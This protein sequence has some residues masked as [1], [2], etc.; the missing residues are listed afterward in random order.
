VQAA[1][2]KIVAEVSAVSKPAWVLVSQLHPLNFEADVLTLEFESQAEVDAFK[3]SRG[4]P[5]TLRSAIKT[6]LGITVKFKPAIGA[7]K[8]VAAAAT[9]VAEP[10]A[11]EEVE[12][13]AVVEVEP[14]EQPSEPEAVTAKQNLVHEGATFGEAVLRDVLGATPIE[15]KK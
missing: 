1:W 8:P 11:Q 10:E 13:E 9:K 12:P 15:K 3:N 2:P 4:A 5:D 14:E 6:V 7:A